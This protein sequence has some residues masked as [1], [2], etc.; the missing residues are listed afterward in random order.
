MSDQQ[1]QH[2]A[3]PCTYSTPANTVIATTPMVYEKRKLTVGNDTF[4]TDQIVIRPNQ[5]AQTVIQIPDVI[6]LT[7]LQT[8][9]VDVDKTLGWRIRQ[10]CQAG[11]RGSTTRID[12]W[13]CL[14]DGT[15]FYR[16]MNKIVEEPF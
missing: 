6:Q 9:A 16:N 11:H 1:P 2:Y 10:Y 5:G 4:E 14:K 3:Y 7:G 12:D 8:L 15:W 13:F